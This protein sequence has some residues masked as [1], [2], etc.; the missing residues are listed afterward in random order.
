M[1]PAFS[2]TAVTGFGKYTVWA[3]TGLR[4]HA[5]E[6]PVVARL[7]CFVVRRRNELALP[8]QSRAEV[9]MIDVE[10]CFATMNHC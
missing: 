4:V 6:Q 1:A 5:P 9:R 10:S 2:G 7:H 3:N 8:A